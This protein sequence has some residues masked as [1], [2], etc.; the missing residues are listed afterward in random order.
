[1]KQ[2]F[3]V[4]VTLL[5]GL[6]LLF[7]SNKS[8][9][10]ILEGYKIGDVVDDFS[11][12]NTNGE[13]VSLSGYLEQNDVDGV[14]VIFTCNTCPYAVAYEDRIIELHE[15]FTP[16]GYPVLAINPNDPA[17]KPG[18]S[19]EKMK[20]RAEKKGFPFDYTFDETQEVVNKFGA[21]KTPHVFLVDGEMKVRYIGA[22]DNN[23]TDP[24]GVTSHYVEDAISAVGEGNEPDPTVTKAVGCSI[25]FKRGT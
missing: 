10:I 1:M 16:K 5:L 15:K 14:I 23:A 20:I 12:K 24:S 22:I 9:D 6:G 8:P 3:G 19:F 17:I 2:I 4:T 13:M 7:T 18:D 25:K 21:T 11:L